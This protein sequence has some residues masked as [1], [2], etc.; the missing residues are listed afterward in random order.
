MIG[1]QN[2]ETNKDFHI[3]F[4][5]DF[6]SFPGR[7]SLDEKLHLYNRDRMLAQPSVFEAFGMAQAEAMS[8]G[9]PVITNKVGAL[10][11]VVGDCGI[12]LSKNDPKELAKHICRLFEDQILWSNLSAKGHRRIENN[13]SYQLRE[14][15][16]E[17]IV[18][19]VMKG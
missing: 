18:R 17:C 12:Y 4:V 9:V 14:K 8:C 11:E 15:K 6:I 16:I 3:A 7:I 10:S 19:K 1:T 13:F 2:I 5:G